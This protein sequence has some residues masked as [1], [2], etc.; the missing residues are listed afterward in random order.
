MP[1]EKIRSPGSIPAVAAG[2]PSR[3]EITL[4]CPLSSASATPMPTSSL[5]VGAFKAYIRPDRC[6]GVRIEAR[7]HA[8][9]RGIDQL[10]VGDRVDCVL[11]DTL[12][13]FV[14]QIE[15]L[16]NRV[17]VAL[18]RLL[19]LLRLRLLSE[20]DAARSKQSR[21]QNQPR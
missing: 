21:R 8:A 13:G 1:I 11:T 10:F 14:E 18:L 6:S 19:L 15:L 4:S 16:V 5:P 20:H 9:D 17:L 2:E 12:E 3:G 7:Q